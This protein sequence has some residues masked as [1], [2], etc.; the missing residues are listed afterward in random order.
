MFRILTALATLSILSVSANAARFSW[1]GYLQITAFSG[2]C[3][4]DPRGT[5]GMAQF[6]PEL[7]GTDNGPGSRLIWYEDIHAKGYSLANGL[8]TSTFKN[9]T[10]NYMGRYIFEDNPGL[11]KVRFL[12]Q[13]PATITTTT[14]T[15]NITG[16]IQAYDAMPLCRV[17]FQTTLVPRL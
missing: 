5:R 10:A 9:A 3:D 16:Q 6:M 2:T 8:F 7:A 13:V 12:S 14:K 11:V 1:V 4:Y 17:T 15:I